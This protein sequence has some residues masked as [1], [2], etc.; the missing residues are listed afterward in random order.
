[1]S[2]ISHL[3]KG[4]QIDTPITT[5]EYIENKALQGNQ[6]IGN[7][8]NKS[9]FIEDA[10]ISFPQ[11]WYMFNN[12]NKLKNYGIQHN[13][14]DTNITFTS[15]NI[16]QKHINNSGIGITELNKYIIQELENNFTISFWCK[17]SG[18][19]FWVYYSNNNYIKLEI[20]TNSILMNGTS[21]GS[22]ILDI[23][24]FNH[25]VLTNES[26]YVNNIKIGNI[27]LPSYIFNLDNDI[28]TLDSTVEY[29]DLRI[30]N[31]LLIDTKITKLFNL[32]NN[33][34]I[35]S[36]NGEL[37]TYNNKIINFD[38]NVSGENSLSIIFWIN[39]DNVNNDIINYGNLKI[40]IKDNRFYAETVNKNNVFSNRKLVKESRYYFVCVIIEN[41][42]NSHI[43]KLYIDNFPVIGKKFKDTFTFT[44]ETAI[45]GNNI[46]NLL[47]Y[48]K[49][50]DDNEIMDLYIRD[51]KLSEVISDNLTDLY[52]DFSKNIESIDESLYN[53]QLHS[54]SGVNLTGNTGLSDNTSPSDETTTEKTNQYDIYKFN[55][56]PGYVGFKDDL[57]AWYKFEKS[58][59][60]PITSIAPNM[61]DSS[62]C[63]L[64]FKHDGSTD[65][66]TSYTVNFPVNTECDILI[67]GGGGS[68]G[69]SLGGGGGGGGVLFSQFTS[70]NLLP[71]G[72]YNIK[73][74]KGGEPVQ[75]DSYNSKRLGNTGASSEFHTT[76]VY[77]GGGGGDY[78]NHD[79]LSGGSG[80]GAG[81]QIA[82][83]GSKILPL[84]GSVITLQNSSYYG[85]VGESVS[86]TSKSGN[87][88]SANF[89]SDITGI[90][91]TY[92]TGG[93]G[94]IN[95]D[96][97]EITNDNGIN[98]GDG[99]GGGGWSLST[100][101]GSGSSGIVIIRYSSTKTLENVIDSTTNKLQ[102]PTG[103]I[104]TKTIGTFSPYSLYWDGDIN[105]KTDN[106]YLISSL[107]N[108]TPPL[109]ISFWKKQ[110]KLVTEETL[111]INNKVSL[112]INSNL[113]VKFSIGTTSEIIENQA[114]LDW[115]FWTITS[116]GTSN[117]LYRDG[118]EL[119][120]I[121]T[122]SLILTET[123]E[124]MIG[125]KSINSYVDQ[126]PVTEYTIL[127]CDKDNLI[128]QWKFD[129]ATN[130]NYDSISQTNKGTLSS[131]VSSTTGQIEEAI[132]FHKDGKNLSYDI[133]TSLINFQTT[134]HS[135]TFWFNLNSAE[136]TYGRLIQLY[137]QSFEIL[138]S[139][140]TGKGRIAIRDAFSASFNN[141][142]VID[143]NQWYHFAVIVD[144]ETLDFKL[145]K[146]G[147]SIAAFEVDITNTA[148]L[149]Q[150]ITLG[151]LYDLTTRDGDGQI[152]DFRIYNKILTATEIEYLA[153]N[154]KFILTS[155]FDASPS[156]LEDL[157][158]WKKSLT[159]QQI[160]DCMSIYPG[161]KNHA[162]DLYLWYKFENYPW[163]TS[164][165]KDYSGFK[166]DGTITNYV[167]SGT[168]DGD[169]PI[170]PGHENNLK[171]WLK[172]NGNL[173]DSSDNKII[174]SLL[175]GF[176]SVSY[177]SI[178][179]IIGNE[180]LV[181]NSADTKYSF[182]NYDN[183]IPDGTKE[184]TFSY[185]IRNDDGSGRIIRYQPASGNKIILGSYTDGNVYQIWIMGME[186]L[187][188]N[189]SPKFITYQNTN[190][191]HLVF[192]VD[193]NIRTIKAYANS[194]DITS[195]FTLL[196]AI[197]DFSNGFINELEDDKFIFLNAP[198]H[199]SVQAFRGELSDFRIY[200]K[201]LSETEIKQIYGYT[202]SRQQG[203]ISPYAY[204]FNGS[205]IDNTDNAYITK[206]TITDFPSTFSIAFWKKCLDKSV[207]GKSFVLSTGSTN[208]IEIDVSNTVSF[209][210][211]DISNILEDYNDISWHHW[212]F[213]YSGTE[214]DIYKDGMNRVGHM[215]NKKTGL[216]PLDFTIEDHTIYVGGNAIGD[217]SPSYLEDFRIY[218]KVLSGIE[219]Q[220]I[221]NEWTGDIVNKKDNLKL[222]YQLNNNPVGI[223][224]YPIFAGHESNLVAWYKFDV[225]NSLEDE[226]GN[227][228]L[229]NAGDVTFSSDTSYIGQSANFPNSSSTG[230][231]SIGGGL[232]P[233]AIWSVNGITFSLWYKIDFAGSDQYGRL[234]EFGSDTENRITIIA[235]NSTTNNDLGLYA[236]GG[237]TGGNGPNPVFGTGTLD[238]TWHHMIWSVDASGNWA[239]FVDGIDQ[240][241][242]G[243]WDIPEIT[244]G[245][246]TLRFGKSIYKSDTTQDLKGYLDDFRIY[247]KV[248]SETEI[249]QIYGDRSKSKFDNGYVYN[250]A[251]TSPY[252]DGVLKNVLKNTNSLMVIQDIKITKMIL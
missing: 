181:N 173:N 12:T 18:I 69:S 197:N 207:E 140:A 192:T 130:L 13:N 134:S 228:P 227:Y 111:S 44:N 120:N 8:K 46:E 104:I 178:N 169:Y 233:H 126:D 51:T 87:G 154:K 22:V 147:V 84:Y 183:I 14:Y 83:G 159:H 39:T 100:F 116:D 94:R 160:I 99:G 48:N 1:M 35:N 204:F 249:K 70:S 236:K 222:W 133:P 152:D 43:L 10:D 162:N 57:Y 163:N 110:N 231:L 156:Y 210:I 82:S 244:G 23:T 114:D 185:W 4:Y 198:G 248:L 179:P 215:I 19:V 138:G 72:T 129:D 205:T 32:G 194:V 212:V 85:N 60:E 246:T 157:R 27:I 142:D 15:N 189:S 96:D 79:G 245:Y 164:N 171:L 220:Q 188:N 106:S 26:V 203:Y 132:D 201:V 118:R 11:L 141:D 165:I 30:F 25:I 88:G 80:G 117:Q 148:N 143:L 50:L 209:T 235:K 218:N 177:S 125:S 214:M 65:N 33:I 67:V 186:L 73:V 124:L 206:N 36:T 175:S 77:G 119:G 107:S 219:I 229:T 225:P 135:F 5:K 97:N 92:S 20:D 234:F 243:I 102:I 195:Q 122:E 247:N 224:D 158:I 221:Y 251:N 76:I 98:Y 34:S 184:I 37:G 223:P 55:K 168:F 200:N 161:Y 211:G 2:F 93:I 137:L 136:N 71:A 193:F 54:E 127:D 241:I 62:N 145:Y 187:Y 24:Q 230:Y 89:T 226:T 149:R 115:H 217:A 63:Y 86:I 66:Q 31:K 103:S 90:N 16:T 128:L 58:N 155:P 196:D 250:Y 237:H 17:G 21:I 45:N 64:A 52:S 172:L 29:Y 78:Q 40:G 139:S 182:I 208:V 190:W 105:D 56:Y 216:I 53:L 151:K 180:Y 213:T 238:N 3:L 146:N 174:V 38:I 74:G 191:T 101:S 59:T 75:S 131:G 252:F 199:E 61:I 176:S 41:V 81:F 232:D 123:D 170:F 166:R 28:I 121:I 42:D 239:A 202:L 150:R 91:Y 68:G 113:A 240:N 108:V 153:N 144:I 9:E 49:S 47:I 112:S 167:S 95:G 109:S 7:I 6:T 242:D